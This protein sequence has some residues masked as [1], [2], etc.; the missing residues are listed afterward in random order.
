MEIVKTNIILPDVLSRE[1]IAAGIDITKN[2]ENYPLLSREFSEFEL[3]GIAATR[4]AMLSLPLTH[5]SGSPIMGDIRPFADKPAHKYGNTG[6]LDIDLGLSQCTFMRWG[7]VEK[8]GG[9]GRYH[10]LIDTK[11]ILND[12]RCFVT[13]N[14]VTSATFTADVA[15]ADITEKQRADIVKGYFA[16]I[17]SGK[18]WLEL[19]ARKTYLQTRFGGAVELSSLADFGEIKFFGPIKQEH[20]IEN[21]GPEEEH[22]VWADLYRK[23]FVVGPVVRSQPRRVSFY[24]TTPQEL[25]LQGTEARD[26]WANLHANPVSAFAT[27]TEVSV[28]SVEQ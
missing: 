2:Y 26:F 22:A 3:D 25:G 5:S 19:I 13:P 27:R 11:K 20:I 21:V 4:E 6:Q 10:A 14:D 24:D 9:S 18:D 1:A 8:S 16:K 7:A 17:L 15:Y 28:L 12:P 23:G